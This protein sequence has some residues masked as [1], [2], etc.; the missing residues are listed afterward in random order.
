MGPFTYRTERM[1][2][3]DLKRTAVNPYRLSKALLGKGSAKTEVRTFEVNTGGLGP[4]P[5]HAM[6]LLAG[7]RWLVYADRGDDPDSGGPG[8]V[9]LSDMIEVDKEEMQ[10]FISFPLLGP[11]DSWPSVNAVQSDPVNRRLMI[12]VSYLSGFPLCVTNCVPSYFNFLTDSY[13]QTNRR[14]PL[15][16]L[17]REGYQYRVANMEPFSQR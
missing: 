5:Q 6:N 9:C 1:S 12:A 16:H 11:A 15:R 10:P 2:L 17:A 3:Q 14:D 8:R 13:N 4:P 7:G